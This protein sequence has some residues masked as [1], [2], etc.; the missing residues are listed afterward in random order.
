L[1][2]AVL[3]GKRAL[4][5][6]GITKTNRLPVKVVSIGNL[7]LGGTGKTPAVIAVALEA[8]KRGLKPCILTRG[9]KGKAKGPCIMDKDNEEFFNVSQAGDETV[10]MVQNL[11]DIPVVKGKNRFLA[12]GYAL[13]EVGTYDIDTFILD[14]G[15]Q[16]WG[17]YRDI[18][19]LLIDA[20][21]PF[22][23]GRLFPEGML[24]EPIKSMNRADIIVITK[25]DMTSGETVTNIIQKIKR[26]NS[27]A[28]VYTACHKPVSLIDISGETRNLDVLSNNRLYTFAGIANTIYFQSILRSCG[29]DIVKFKKFRDHY[30]YNQRDINNIRREAQGLDII[31]TE[32][33]LIKLNGLDL[34]DNIYAL[35]I[36]FSIDS[37]FYIS[38]F[39]GGHNDKE[40]QHQD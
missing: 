2:R 34:P 31:T 20:S 13:D 11:V 15:F 21:N 3:W 17:L 26:Y 35:K 4:Y 6:I 1:Y 23:N 16:H 10:L 39:G 5:N 27:K 32:K 25:A 22:G 24:R 29:A 18:D 37:E 9:Y 14:D 36:E 19:V 8:K 12:G 33:D 28:P 30:H 40:H 7:T 38:I